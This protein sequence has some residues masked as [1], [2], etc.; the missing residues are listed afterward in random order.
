M[1]PHGPRGRR[2]VAGPPPICGQTFPVERSTRGA[3]AAT[4]RR[5]VS[6]TRG[7]RGVAWDRKADGNLFTAAEDQSVRLTFVL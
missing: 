7:I 4:E 2:R 1:G 5:D 3:G 6:H